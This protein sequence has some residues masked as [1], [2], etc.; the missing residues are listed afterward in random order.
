MKRLFTAVLGVALVLFAVAATPAIE[1]ATSF[2]RLD[3][4]ESPALTNEVYL[5]AGDFLA[6]IGTPA[7][8]IIGSANAQGWALDAATDES[9]SAMLLVPDSFDPVD[10]TCYIGWSSTATSGDAIFDVTTVPTA[11]T[12]DSGLAG[13]TDSVTDRKAAEGIVQTALDAFGRLDIVIN[14]ASILRDRIFHRMSEDEWD[15]AIAVHLKGSFNVSRAAANHFKEQQPGAFVHMTSTSGLIGNFGQANYAAAKLG[16]A[17][18]SKS[19]ALDMGRY[20]VR[21][22]C[23][24]PFAWSRLIGG[25]SCLSGEA[26][27]ELQVGVISGSIVT[28]LMGATALRDAQSKRGS[29]PPGH[30]PTLGGSGQR[31][32]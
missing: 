21:S 1:R 26:A 9:I 5:P 8:G 16:I 10:V 22:N 15:A 20:A 12:E 3:L 13:N 6:R 19:L 27:A 29:A 32:H 28:I 2:T 4:T 14:N 30:E 31:I 18:L 7:R 24:A 17:G 25:L 11:Q 23:I